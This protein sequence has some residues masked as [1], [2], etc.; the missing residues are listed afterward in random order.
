MWVPNDPQKGPYQSNFSSARFEI[1][2]ADNLEILQ[3]KFKHFAR[4]EA[5][6]AVSFSNL[7]EVHAIVPQR[8][9]SRVENNYEQVAV[10]R[11]LFICMSRYSAAIF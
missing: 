4:G 10:G 8:W 9:L 2:S 11:Q 6:S 3:S 1:R 7:D 5:T